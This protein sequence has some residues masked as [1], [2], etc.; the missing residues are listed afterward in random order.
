[1]KLDEEEESWT[2]NFKVDFFGGEQGVDEGSYEL[3]SSEIDDSSNEMGNN[4]LWQRS[5]N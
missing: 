5:K 1:M 2:T 3:L 4:P